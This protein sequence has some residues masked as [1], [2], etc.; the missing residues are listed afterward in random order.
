MLECLFLFL[1][2]IHHKQFGR[3]F[4]LGTHQHVDGGEPGRKPVNLWLMGDWWSPSQEVCSTGFLLKA[5][6]LIPDNPVHVIFSTLLKVLTEHH[7]ADTFFCRLSETVTTKLIP[8]GK[9]DGI[10]LFSHPF[11]SFANYCSLKQSQPL[12]RENGKLSRGQAVGGD[13]KGAVT[14]SYL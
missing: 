6:N 12:G 11:C 7:K 4:A 8:L 5:Y 9:I 3:R 10:S 1:V 13:H 2:H 14:T